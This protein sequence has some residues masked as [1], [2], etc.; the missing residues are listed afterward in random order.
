MR[1]RSVVQESILPLATLLLLTLVAAG[2][3]WGPGLLN[4]RGGGD[5]PF[6]LLR[7]HQLTANLRAGTFPARWMPDDAYGFGYPF[8]SYYAALPYYLA[9]GFNLIGVDILSAV[10]LT[11]TVF[12]AAAAVGMYEWARRALRSRTG[13][14]L[15]AVAY[16]V[17]PYHLVN[18]YVRGDS[19]SEFAAFA[20]YPLILWG[21]DRLTERPSLRR[22]IPPALAYAG[23]I[24]THN[25][26]AFIFS[27]CVLL[28]YVTFHASRITPRKLLPTVA[29]II[30]SLVIGILLAAWY[31][32]P[33]LAE[34][35]AV[36]MTAQTSG[37]FSYDKHFRAADLVQ[38]KLIFDYY[39][40]TPDK[41]TAF[42]AMGLVQTILALAGATIAIL[43]CIRLRSTG[44]DSRFEISYLIFVLVG[45]L[46]TTWLVTPLSRPLWDILSPLQLIQFPWRILSAQALFTALLAGAI[47]PL[48][49]LYLEKCKGGHQ[50][51][52]GAILALLLAVAGLAGL[53]PEY[54]PIAAAEVTVE[55]LQLYELFTG[56][57]GTTIRHEWLP[58]W[59][60]PRPFTGPALFDPGEPPRAIPLDGALV[61]AVE[62]AHAPTRRVWTV[63]A[64]DGGAE[65]AFPL[66]YWPGW[67]ATVDN[68][69]VETRPTPSSGYLA[70]TVPAGAHTV[71]IWL[72]RTPI[73]LVAELISLVVGLALLGKGIITWMQ[74]ARGR[75]QKKLASRIL[76]P[77]SCIFGFT[78]VLTLLALFHPRVDASA[79]DLTM[80][81]DSQPYL[82]HNPSGV[83]FDGRRLLSYQY[84]TDHLTPGDTLH[85]TFDW[86]TESE[87]GSA[88]LRLVTPAAVRQPEL[89]A[90]APVA[91][92]I[93]PQANDGALDLPIPGDVGP[94]MY[95]LQ[96]EDEAT[97]VY[98]R[99]IW[100]SAGETVAGQS[101]N[102]TFAD[103]A[104]HLHAAEPSQATPD[105]LDLRLDWSTEKPIAAN[106]G[107]SL[108]LSDPAGSEWARLDTQ[109]GYGFLPTSLWPV[110]RLIHDRYTLP[111]PSGTPPGDDYNLA[112]ILYHVATGESVGEYTFPVM[113]ERVTMRPDVPTVAR[114]GSEL[115]LS[116]TEV[117]ERV[118]QGETLNLTS[119]WLAVEQP[120]AN[121]VAEWRLESTQQTITAT[122]PLAP[123]SPP[124]AWPTG[125]WIAGRATLFIPPTTQPGDYTLSL[126][127]REPASGTSQ[128]S[129]THPQPVRV[130]GCK[131]VWELPEMQQEI[132]AR[133]GDRP[134]GMIEL[135]GY[136]LAQDDD[137]LKL[138]L[139]WQA[140]AVPDQHYM[141]FVHVA[142]PTS[143]RPATQ[144]DTMPRGFTYPTGMWAPGE[145]VSEEVE[146]S[147]EDD[148]IQ[149]LQATDATGNPLPDDRLVLPDSIR[150][151]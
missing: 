95:L 119:Y 34:T 98:L 120:T 39:T 138:T 92:T 44:Q 32:L 73:R 18:I 140:L 129:Y 7:V 91:V 132:G 83:A 148:P 16:T 108:R 84:G 118:R 13:G 22:I 71:A 21:L 141:L 121:Y 122:L 99:P 6:N 70:L 109:P 67:R 150:V 104:L 116:G 62:I 94:G 125:A 130:E 38:P 79:A 142:D 136:D 96:L 76:P 54:L 134:G 46:L 107:I 29:L 115:A 144:I 117:P 149:R 61:S 53:R 89:S 36:Q 30:V 5:S 103:G 45:L 42:A 41:P 57:I 11:Q 14:W 56:N 2:P 81:F 35:G 86:E 143:G 68:A 135:A 75:K 9:A 124:T 37:Y 137:T 63:E 51:I 114:F 126:T 151:P 90:I 77:A 110:D 146:F 17:A 49:P 43:T 10:K 145:V 8:F 133:F 102:A 3:L 112:V 93:S 28:P 88:T 1:S 60:V 52:I 128:G 74:E 20:F 147:L 15:A 123:G 27:L 65:V 127:V 69:P 58:R 106:Y 4:T 66:Y 139:Y 31:W 55:R 26:S 72:G 101:T 40:F 82:H 85:V 78:I 97:S 87:A 24:V 131:R 47:P 111:L 48:L 100:V 113:L 19:L 23:L 50:W 33:T 105:R 25:L 64:S 80:D 12:F 59:V